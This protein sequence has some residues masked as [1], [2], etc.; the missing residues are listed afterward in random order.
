MSFKKETT[1]MHSTKEDNSIQR[2]SILDL[3]NMATIPHTF[4]ITFTANTQVNIHRFSHQ[5]L[6]PLGAFKIYI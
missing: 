1:I 3:K 6:R 5:C 4:E 2:G